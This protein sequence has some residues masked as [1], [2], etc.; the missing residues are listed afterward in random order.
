MNRDSAKKDINAQYW[1][2]FGMLYV[3]APGLKM[4]Q[5]TTMPV[6]NFPYRYYLDQA[7]PNDDNVSM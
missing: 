4:K 2:K 1:S 6:L 3:I 7:H 5:Q